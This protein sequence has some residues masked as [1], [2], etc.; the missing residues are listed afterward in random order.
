MSKSVLIAALLLVPC[1]AAQ[2]KGGRTSQAADSFHGDEIPATTIVF[3]DP[4]LDSP[5]PLPSTVMDGLPTCSND[6]IAI[7]QFYTSPPAFDGKA[8]YA[9]KGNGTAKQLHLD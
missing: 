4:K 6:G 8:I 5:L 1:V 3:S 9:V 7:F 2:D